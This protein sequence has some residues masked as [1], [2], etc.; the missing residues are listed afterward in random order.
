MTWSVYI[1]IIFQMYNIPNP[2]MLLESPPWSK[3]DRKEFTLT[4]V[5]S[6]HEHLLRE[7]SRH[8]SKMKYSNIDLIALTGRSH[9]VLMNVMT[10]HDVDMLRTTVKMLIS[11]YLTHDR[12]SVN[13][14]VFR[15]LYYIVCTCLSLD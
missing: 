8:N 10:P 5:R 12:M 6:Y 1:R 4:L 2:L 14:E 13:S 11:D 7:K 9:P 15:K 3:S